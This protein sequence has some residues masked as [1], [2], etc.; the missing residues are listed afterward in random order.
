MGMFIKRTPGVT[1]TGGD[2]FEL[3]T[4]YVSLALCK[5]LI[6]L[7]YIYQQAWCKGLKKQIVPNQLTVQMN[8][9]P[10]AKSF[11]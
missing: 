2:C 5:R 6:I 4:A 11:S 10:N 9:L 3:M 8:L 1:L 7:W